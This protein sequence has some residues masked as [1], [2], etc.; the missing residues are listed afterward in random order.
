VTVKR[1]TMR[2]SEPGM[3]SWFSIV[4][5]CVP[6]C[7]AWAVRNYYNLLITKKPAIIPSSLFCMLL[8]FGITVFWPN[9]ST[10]S[11]HLSGTAGVC[12]NGF[13]VRGG[14][15]VEVTATLPWSLDRFGITQFEF[16]KAEPAGNFAFELKRGG[17]MG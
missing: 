10:T 6:G 5:C 3:A 1:P 15:R 17:I 7:W 14:Q 4:A 13:Y 9:T 12:L 11:I 8:V 2:R 16:R